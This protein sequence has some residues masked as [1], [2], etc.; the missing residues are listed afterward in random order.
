MKLLIKKLFNKNKDGFTMMEMLVS[1]SIVALISTIMLA[2]YHYYGKKGNLTMAAQLLAS[3]IRLAQSYSLGLKQFGNNPYSDTSG[4]WGVSL[5]SASPNN[6]HYY[7][8]FDNDNDMTRNVSTENYQD[9]NLPTGIVISDILLNG[10]SQSPFN[11]TYLPPD[12][13]IS[14]C[15]AS[16]C[17]SFNNAEIIL[18]N[19][20]GATSSVIVNTLGL[21]DVKN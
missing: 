12:P 7:V 17:S 19:T 6:K 16:Y 15:N 20:D 2:N 11:I 21:V 3:N 1:I 10:V 18:R 14:I 4:G 9:I 5:T 13:T 8:F